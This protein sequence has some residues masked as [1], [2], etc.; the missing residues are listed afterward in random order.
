MKIRKRPEGE[1][2]I[3]L[4]KLQVQAPSPASV[5][6]KKITGTCRMV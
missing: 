4:T 6:A 1:F 2:S 5:S 3:K